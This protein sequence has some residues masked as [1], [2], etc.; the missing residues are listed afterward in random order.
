MIEYSPSDYPSLDG[1]Q[2]Q[3]FVSKLIES[4]LPIERKMTCKY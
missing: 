2:K 4:C 3:L 1:T